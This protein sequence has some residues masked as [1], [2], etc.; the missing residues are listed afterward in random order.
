MLF[1]SV[2]LPRSQHNTK[3]QETGVFFHENLSKNYNLSF[4]NRIAY[5]MMKHII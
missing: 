2:P 5:D 1:Y 3:M 4:Q